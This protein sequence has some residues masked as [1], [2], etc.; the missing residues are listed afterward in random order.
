MC[1]YIFV[2]CKGV[3]PTASFQSCAKFENVGKNVSSKCKQAMQFPPTENTYY[4]TN[5]KKM[6]QSKYFNTYT[7]CNFIATDLFRYRIVQ[8]KKIIILKKINLIFP[9]CFPPDIFGNRDRDFYIEK[10]G[11]FIIWQSCDYFVSGKDLLTFTLS[12][13]IKICII[14]DH[15]SSRSADKWKC[16]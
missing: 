3:C 9:L 7:W 8:G 10:F 11:L 15:G 5:K 16:H 4:A 6:N 13:I 12:R 2:D 14:L 1:F